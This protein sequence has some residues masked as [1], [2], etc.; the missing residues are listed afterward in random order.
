MEHGAWAQGLG[1]ETGGSQLEGRENGF[2]GRAMLTGPG[3][4]RSFGLQ[5]VSGV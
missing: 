5:S 4:W 1:P 2:G 3:L